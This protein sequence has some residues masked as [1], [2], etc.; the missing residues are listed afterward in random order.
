MRL[1][2]SNNGSRYPKGTAADLN[3]ISGHRDVYETT[4]PGQ[5]LYDALPWIR[6]TAARL[7]AQA[8]REAAWSQ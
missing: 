3:V 2:S 5:A 1:V 7:R 8:I 6:R 4:C